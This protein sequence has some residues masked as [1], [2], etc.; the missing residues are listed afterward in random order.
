M[1]NWSFT[2]LFVLIIFCFVLSCG[3]RYKEDTGLTFEGT[4]TY[5]ESYI[6]GERVS[7]SP[8][9]GSFIK[10][11]DFEGENLL[12]FYS[13][14][15][16]DSSFFYRIQEVGS[17]TGNTYNLY[18]R[19]IMDTVDVIYSYPQFDEEG[20]PVLDESGKQ[21]ITRDT[22]REPQKPLNPESE[23]S[24]EK[25][26]GTFIF[27]EGVNLNMMM[28]RYNVDEKGAPTTDLFI[29]DIYMRPIEIE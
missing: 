2:S 13:G 20:N 24:P 5:L 4:W 16:Y 9:S 15:R 29:E 12:L 23:Y 8:S 22:I 27:N 21:I 28:K 10:A 19:R 25:Y 26:Y 3:E 14:G 17:K 6:D 1:K 7:L 11:R 18:L